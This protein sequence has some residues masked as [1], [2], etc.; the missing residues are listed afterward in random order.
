M[1]GG[2]L[3]AVGDRG[4]FIDGENEFEKL[5][6]SN[7]LECCVEQVSSIYRFQILQIYIRV[8]YDFGGIE[9]NWWH[10]DLTNE[11]G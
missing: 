6:L 8:G 5:V 10:V 9:L 1:V 2:D 4:L 7:L 3:T 11:K